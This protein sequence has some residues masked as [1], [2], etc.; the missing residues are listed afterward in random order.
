[1]LGA[2]T[3]SPTPSP[4]TILGTGVTDQQVSHWFDVFLGTP[5]T[6]FFIVVVAILAR[7]LLHRI[8]D[9]VADGVV[10]GR[11]GLGRFE[12]RLPSALVTSSVVST[13][14]EQRA[15]TMASILKS[16]GTATIGVI[17]ALMILDTLGIPTGPLLA[18]AGIVGIAVGFGAQAL[19]RDVISGA[20]MLVEDQYGVGDVVDLGD[21]SGVVEAVGLR[22]TRVRDV[23]G[24]VWYIR[25]GQ[26]VRVG[27]RSQGWAR[28]VLDVAIAYGEDIARA[29]NLLM[30]VATGLREDERFG[31]LVLEEPQ[32][33]GIES[34]T[35]DGVVL[36]LVVKTRPLE[37]WTVTRE[38]RRRIKERFD[39]EGVR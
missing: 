36:R 21:A 26:I 31:P 37:Q 29:E 20:F 19:V 22:V 13:R 6:I 39:A 2:A 16:L 17:A 11:A 27:N 24:T 34:M 12:D 32:V 18:S 14:R 5:L 15:R 9:R 1:M 28:A 4:T 10:S 25:N 35:A 30:E 38:L 8:V 33:W 23:D 7:F 3:P